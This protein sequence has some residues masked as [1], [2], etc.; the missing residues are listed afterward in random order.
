ML[1]QSM[2]EQFGL[3]STPILGSKFC[4]EG[5]AFSPS[6]LSYSFNTVFGWIVGSRGLAG[7]FI[8]LIL[9]SEGSRDR[10]VTSQLPKHKKISRNLVW[11]AST[12]SQAAKSP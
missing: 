8:F 10:H 7:R 12:T 5:L 11:T 4:T 2:Q 1:Q 9:V 3:T 6:D